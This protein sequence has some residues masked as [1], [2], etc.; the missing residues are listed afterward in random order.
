MVRVHGGGDVDRMGLYL[1][2]IKR[3][4]AAYL[5]D[6]RYTSYV[7]IWRR[8]RMS[9]LHRNYGFEMIKGDIKGYTEEEDVRGIVLLGTS[10]SSTGYASQVLID[11]SNTLSSFT[12]TFLF[13]SSS[14]I[15]Q[16]RSSICI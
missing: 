4:A 2:I 12:P 16:F 14:F 11:M 13:P 3:Y 8:Y 1:L 7:M 15:Q 6:E 9:M 5:E 10:I